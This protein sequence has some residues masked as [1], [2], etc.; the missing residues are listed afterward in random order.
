MI[1]RD[2]EARPITPA[3][4]IPTAAEGSLRSNPNTTLALDIDDWLFL[5]GH[6]VEV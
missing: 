5:F 3:S 1:F 6:D 4:V 2:T